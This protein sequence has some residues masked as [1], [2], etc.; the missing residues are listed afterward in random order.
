MGKILK[1]ALFLILAMPVLAAT[2]Y[3]DINVVGG[4]D[5]GSS[6]INAWD[7]IAEAQA[8]AR[9]GDPG[10]D[11]VLIKDGGPRRWNRSNCILS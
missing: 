3:V 2:Y 11:T 10:G 4:G 8:G 5:D 1:L 6:W 9:S 7:T